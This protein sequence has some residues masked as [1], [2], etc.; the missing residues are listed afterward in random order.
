MNTMG[1]RSPLT[2]RLIF[3]IT[4]AVEGATGL[5]QN[6]K[7]RCQIENRPRNK[8]AARSLSGGSPRTSQFIFLITSTYLDLLSGLRNRSGTHLV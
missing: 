6:D 8:K 3:T 2:T 5:Y 7:S 4:G 1:A